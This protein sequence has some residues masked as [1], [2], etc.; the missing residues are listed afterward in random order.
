MFCVTPKWP[1]PFQ[2][3]KYPICASHTVHPGQKYYCPFCSM[4]IRV[5]VTTQLWDK[6]TEWPQITLAFLRSK[7]PICI[8]HTP[9]RPKFPSDLLYDKQF[10]RCGGPALR[11]VHRMTPNWPNKFKVKS[12]ILFPIYSRRPSFRPFRSTMSHYQG[13]RDFCYFPIEYN[14]KLNFSNFHQ[15]EN[16]QHFMRTTIWNL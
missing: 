12:T 1:W 11:K 7:V 4:T 13:N 2:G 3:Q 16:F 15:T 8:L 5:W 9:P 10:S 6:C 14:V